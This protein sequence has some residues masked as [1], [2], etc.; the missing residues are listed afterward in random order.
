[1]AVYVFVGVGVCVYK[2]C[3]L[4]KFTWGPI[5]KIQN[6]CLKLVKGILLG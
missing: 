2:A 6:G 3:S 4:W 5:V 1:M